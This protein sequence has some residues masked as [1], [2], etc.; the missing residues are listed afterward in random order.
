MERLTLV[1]SFNFLIF[2]LIYLINNQSSA[3]Y[4]ITHMN[5]VSLFLICC[6]LLAIQMFIS[7]DEITES[8]ERKQK[9]FAEMLLK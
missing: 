3:L 7:F 8:F 4:F 9:T 2:I 1:C 5:R 6:H